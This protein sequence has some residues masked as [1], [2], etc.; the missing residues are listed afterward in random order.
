MADGGATWD[1][2]GTLD[3]G[4]GNTFD[5]AGAT[6]STIFD[7]QAW[8][9]YVPSVSQRVDVT[10]TDPERV[11]WSLYTGATE[12]DKTFVTVHG[13]DGDF[14][15]IYYLHAGVTYHLVSGAYDGGDS[16]AA[17]QVIV[18]TTT[19]AASPWNA[20]LRD[21]DD[22]QLVVSRG[23]LAAENTD[24]FSW[25]P[26]W[27]NDVYGLPL[28]SP[29]RREGNWGALQALGGPLV[30]GAE[31]C[32]V[33][34]AKWGDYGSE[35]GWDGTCTSLSPAGSFVAHAVNDATT[36]SWDTQ[37]NDSPGGPVADV[38]DAQIF[39]RA[40]PF[41]FAAVR[42]H[43]EERGTLPFPDPV[44]DGYPAD[45][46]IEWEG[47]LELLQIE[48]AG[49]QT[50]PP[51]AAGGAYDISVRYML[52]R[53]YTPSYLGGDPLTGLVWT[54]W[55]YGSI[56]EWDETQKTDLQFS[57]SEGTPEWVVVDEVVGGTDGWGNLAA[58]FDEPPDEVAAIA[59]EYS[60]S[61]SMDF[62]S[63]Y[64][65]DAMIAVRYTLRS[66]RYRWVY[67][68]PTT[69]PSPGGIQPRRI[70]QRPL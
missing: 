57:Y 45:S 2:A 1:T 46:E 67:E 23:E 12:A 49:D 35:G 56:D 26:T 38:V 55:R 32:T 51:A 25:G 54:D 42:D 65:R 33:N 53:K 50:T 40:L 68:G 36:V 70:F 24:E 4:S 58:V 64:S 15:G 37:K 34:H 5:V 30:T 43:L 18:T 41:W 66:P 13:F 61:G 59:L 39:A 16:P 60:I 48:L 17:Y 62:T 63:S 44:A 47:D 20:A 7:N 27:F 21:R 6:E 31:G 28:R 8:W 11:G 9:V 22:N 52:R 10:V 69:V 14:T 19:L 3:V 29:R